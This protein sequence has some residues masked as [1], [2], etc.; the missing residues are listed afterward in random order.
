MGYHSKLSG[1][2]DGLHSP[3]GNDIRFKSLMFLIGTAILLGYGCHSA[4]P[5]TIYNRACTLVRRAHYL[6]VHVQYYDKDS[7]TLSTLQYTIRDP[8]TVETIS[9][10][11]SESTVAEKR[12]EAVAS[13]VYA[14]IEVF[15][16]KN[17]GQPAAS[18]LVL[19]E[20]DVAVTANGTTVWSALTSDRLF[21]ML[22]NNKVASTE[23]P[24]TSDSKHRRLQ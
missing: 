12:N 5:T 3:R 9:G 14:I 7:D 2:H 23:E 21:R 18:I 22:K 19:P 20:G 13:N 1:S 10:I 4:S 11:L 17:Q 16:D 24:Q 6:K 15:P 8:E